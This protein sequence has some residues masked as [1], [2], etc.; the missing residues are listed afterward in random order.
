MLTK[1]TSSSRKP[2]HDAAELAALGVSD[3]VLRGY[4]Y[5]LKLI[6]PSDIDCIW[7]CLQE[8]GNRPVFE[9]VYHEACDDKNRLLAIMADD[10]QRPGTITF[11]VISKCTQIVIGLARIHT[12][13]V[14]LAEI[15]Y[16][17]PGH[18]QAYTIDIALMLGTT[19]FEYMNF[20]R[21]EAR[22]KAQHAEDPHGSNAGIRTFD[23]S[24]ILRRQHLDLA[25]SQRSD[26]MVI[27]VRDWPSHKVVYVAWLEAFFVPTGP[28]DSRFDGP[29]PQGDYKIGE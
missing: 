9:D 8:P 23:L 16:F 27:T 20:E 10:S 29:T 25:R 7:Q 4:S 14:E 2:S 22:T 1:Q 19:V 17:P 26:L 12:V 13:S 28:R 18:L 11:S 24:S 21:F 6:Q 15:A 3:D 5:D